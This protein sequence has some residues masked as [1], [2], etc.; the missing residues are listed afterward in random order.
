[1]ADPTTPFR[2]AV[3]ALLPFALILLLAPGLPAFG[4][5]EKGKEEP[6]KEE[7]MQPVVATV[8]GALITKFDIDYE[9][10][11]SGR[12]FKEEREKKLQ[13]L[14]EMMTRNLVTVEILIQAAKRKGIKVSDS[15]I[16]EEI[17]LLA[18]DK[19]GMAAYHR[20]LAQ[21]GMTYAENWNR[22][23]RALYVRELERRLYT[24]RTRTKFVYPRFRE[25]A[26][27][28]R[29]IREYFERHPDEFQMREPG[30]FRILWLRFEDFGSRKETRA[31][32]ESLRERIVSVE[33]PGARAKTFGELAVE[34]SSGDAAKKGGVMDLTDE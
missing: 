3:P 25:I 31:R 13:A 23:K 1:M 22:V 28:P 17:R 24:S 7:G 16:R 33:D 10:G 5:E 19:G 8:N 18:K 32:I 29:Q 26:V 15:M 20:L 34:F 21:Q 2:T 14:R 4:G 11:Y 30:Q 27:T 6:K 9:M 12:V